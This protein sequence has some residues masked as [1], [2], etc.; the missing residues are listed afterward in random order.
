V[1]EQEEQKFKDVTEAYSV[2]SDSQKKMRYDNGQDL[3]DIGIGMGN[4]TSMITLYAK[5]M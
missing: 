1:R 5:A 2:L 4:E 3:E